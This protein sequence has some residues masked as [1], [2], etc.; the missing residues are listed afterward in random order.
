MTPASDLGRVLRRWS[1][2]LAVL[3][4]LTAAGDAAAAPSSR[5]VAF[6]VVDGSVMDILVDRQTAYVAGSFTRIGPPSGPLAVLSAGDGRIRR[7]FPHFT[8]HMNV[9]H[10]VTFVRAIEP[11]GA[12][13]WYV[14]G[15]FLRVDGSYRT[16]LVHLLADGSVDHRFR[17][18]VSGT[19]HALALDREEGTLWVGGHFWRVSGEDRDSLV[20]LEAST[21]A[22][23]P[24]IP[25]GAGPDV[26]DIDIHGERVYAVGGFHTIDGDDYAGAVALS[27]RTGEPLDWDP[28]LALGWVNAVD[29][30]DGIVYLAGRFTQTG[31]LDVGGLVAVRESD[32]SVFP[33]GF[34]MTGGDIEDVVATDRALIVAGL[35]GYHREGARRGLAAFDRRTGVLLPWFRDVEAS[36]A[37]AIEAAGG[38][39]YAAGVTRAAGRT[40]DGLAA[41]DID[42]AEVLPWR[43]PGPDA[44]VHDIAVAGDAVAVGGRFRLL[45]GTRRRDVAA[46]DLR[47]NS[48]I[49]G[50]DARLGPESSQVS[51]L[52]LGG[53]SLW[54]GGAFTRV[55]EAERRNL[56]RVDPAT[57]ALGAGT[58]SPNLSVHALFVRDGRLYLGGVFWSI[59]GEERLRAAAIDLATGALT[60]FA[61]AFDCPVAAFAPMSGRLLAGGGIENDLCDQPG[62]L[63]LLDPV[64]GASDGP[65]MPAGD[66]SGVRALAADGEG[67]VW[68]GG[69]FRRLGDGGPAFLARLRA[70][71]SADARVPMVDREVRAVAAAGGEVLLGGW[72]EE[73]GGADRGGA[74]SAR[75]SNGAVSRWDPRPFGHVPEAVAPLVDGGALLG[76]RFDSTE[77]ATTRGLARFGPATAQ[78]PPALVTAQRIGGDR[79]VDGSQRTDGGDWSGDALRRDIHWLRCDAAGGSCADSGRRGETIRLTAD[80]VGHRLRTEVVAHNDGGASAAVR[81]APGP[82]VAGTRPQPTAP[83]PE[84][85]GE[86]RERATLTAT[87][88]GWAASPDAL[89]FRWQR[90]G[91]R[92][93]RIAG[94]TGTSYTVT[95]ADINSTVRVEVTAVNAAGESRSWSRKLGPVDPAGPQSVPEN[96]RAPRVAG[97]FRN[98]GTLF[99]D[100]GEWTQHPDY[101]GARW[102]RCQA[103]GSDC[104]EVQAGG[105]Y[106][107]GENDVGFRLRIV[108][109]AANEAGRSTLVRSDLTPVVPPPEPPSP[110]IDPPPVPEDPPPGDQDPAPPGDDPPPAGDDPPHAGGGP[111]P[112]LGAPGADDVP[113]SPP[114]ARD[115]PPRVRVLSVRA[116]RRGRVAVGLRTTRAVTVRV[117]LRLAG[118]SA[119]VLPRLARRPV[120][121]ATVALRRSRTIVRLRLTPAAR[122]QLARRDRLTVRVIVAG[123][124]LRV[125]SRALVLRG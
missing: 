29:V 93:H 112:P 76:G 22:L 65:A 4:A 12:G 51:A 25:R 118:R 92:C 78:P 108:A 32:A 100:P 110:P 84:L 13:G 7:T 40:R 125:R 60:P 114:A 101:A 24:W 82:L 86:P 120:A 38:R 95:A 31:D 36:G 115:R 26:N 33:V 117:S 104:R 72:F 90:C 80:D 16:S 23:R 3:V 124:A 107:V 68:V 58:P 62:G 109:G 87:A 20:A 44:L 98:P 103:D 14:G 30:R 73:V 121:R 10:D 56:A 6:P 106:D 2:R 66:Q 71:G 91:Y 113:A 83:E 41:F 89:R 59:D 77:L 50:F 39:L 9:N 64:T 85:T 49:P 54:L 55:A 96:V 81:S 88:G 1:R 75:A 35:D 11:D 116:A 37:H 19:V 45:G 43:P 111:R 67:G 69:W 42:T 70:D 102:E 8:G 15:E 46:V 79:Y 5:P 122:R 119:R 61:H 97:T 28:R 18:D 47:T 99:P 94:A 57:G 74:A 105:V 21:G 48:V 53:G 17:A 63:A 27:R 34:G 123:R 52:A